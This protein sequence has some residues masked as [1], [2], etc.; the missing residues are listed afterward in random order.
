[1]AIYS[2]FLSISFYRTMMIVFIGISLQ[3]EAIIPPDHAET[4]RFP[5]QYGHWLPAQYICSDIGA[6]TLIAL[7]WFFK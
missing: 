5:A 2:L 4:Y 3:G 7:I 1:M 6:A